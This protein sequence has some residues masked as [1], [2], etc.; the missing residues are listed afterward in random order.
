MRVRDEESEQSLVNYK[1]QVRI[2]FR[3]KIEIERLKVCR[4]NDFP[5]SNEQHIYLFFQFQ[6]SQF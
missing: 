5:F 6:E 1:Y 4:Q 3:K 2:T